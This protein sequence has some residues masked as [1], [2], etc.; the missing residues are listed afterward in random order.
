MALRLECLRF[1]AKHLIPL[2][3]KAMLLHLGKMDVEEGNHN[4]DDDDDDGDEAD[5]D[6]NSTYARAFGRW[7]KRKPLA[8]MKVVKANLLEL[9]GMLPAKPMNKLMSDLSCSLIVTNSCQAW[10]ALKN[11][12]MTSCIF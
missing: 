10:R 3:F 5:V 9:K 11:L 2:H 8:V 1:P 6:W 12:G 7:S 4:D